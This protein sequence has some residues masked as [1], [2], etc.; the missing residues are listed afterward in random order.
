MLE[1]NDTTV[2]AM[3]KKSYEISSGENYMYF[4]QRKKNYVQG[5]SYNLSN[6][7]RDNIQNENGKTIW[8]LL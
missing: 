7:V 1:C 5:V 3:E 4:Y 6:L 8:E 2:S